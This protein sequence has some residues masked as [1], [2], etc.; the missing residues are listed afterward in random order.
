MPVQ[1]LPAN[2]PKHVLPSCCTAWM[3]QWPS[4]FGK[5]LLY[6]HIHTQKSNLIIKIFRD[7]LFRDTHVASRSTLLDLCELTLDIKRGC[8]FPSPLLPCKSLQVLGV[9]FFIY[10][11]SLGFTESF[12]Y[13][14]RFY[15]FLFGKCW[16]SPILLHVSHETASASFM[17]AKKKK[18]CTSILPQNPLVQQHQHCLAI[19]SSVSPSEPKKLQPTV[20][21]KPRGSRAHFHRLCWCCQALPQ[22]SDPKQD[23]I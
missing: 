1:C 11:L 23:K 20:P 13:S 10:S 16:F 15:P 2:L 6:A 22:H 7:T 3:L 12:C 21:H 18:L 9:S 14:T 5:F 19:K 8:G 4:A 17:Q